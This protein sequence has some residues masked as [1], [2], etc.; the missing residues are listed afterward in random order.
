MVIIRTAQIADLSALCRLRYAEQPAIHRDRIRAT[1]NQ[2]YFYL[3]AE[4]ECILIGFG[5][6]LLE[7]PPEWSDTLD[8]FPIVVDL[9]VS[10]QHRSQGVGRALLTHMECIVHQHGKTVL[11]LS[12]EPKTNPR[13]LALYERL[14]FQPLQRE[15]YQSA[16]RFTDSD[17]IEHVGEE[18]VIDM[19]KS[20]TVLAR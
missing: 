2:T 7:R 9:F 17:G 11:Y 14:G 16:W 15:P 19:C 18:W 1:D 10:G 6:L 3:V 20:L 8:S 4:R 13:A 12:V 5:L